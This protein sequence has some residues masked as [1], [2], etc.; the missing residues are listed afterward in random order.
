MAVIDDDDD[1]DEVNSQMLAAAAQADEEEDADETPPYPLPT[2]RQPPAAPS[3]P[4]G[5]A[6]Q[7]PAAERL[8]IGPDADAFRRELAANAER[9]LG[10]GGGRGRGGAR[11][12]GTAASVVLNP[13]QRPHSERQ[14]QK[15][16]K[17]AH[18]R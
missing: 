11:G 4:S 5:A 9:G 16:H 7:P 3:G 14:R 15:R 2:G 17:G 10:R 18:E 6:S 13:L 8:F 1:E 12:R